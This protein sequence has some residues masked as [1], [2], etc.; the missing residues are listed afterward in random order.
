MEFKG[1]QPS[2][3]SRTPKYKAPIWPNLQ[4]IGSDLANPIVSSDLANPIGKSAPIC[5]LTGKLSSI[6]RNEWEL[7]NL[8]YI[9]FPD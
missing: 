5:H 1:F 3:R 9:E 2:G 4:E 7:R 8:T 6:C